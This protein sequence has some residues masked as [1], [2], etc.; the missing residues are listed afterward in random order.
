MAAQNGKKLQTLQA[1]IFL[2]GNKR[3][4]IR[5]PRSCRTTC[6]ACR[7]RLTTQGVASQCEGQGIVWHKLSAKSLK[8][9]MAHVKCAVEVVK[10]CINAPGITFFHQ[11]KILVTFHE[12]V[13][14]LEWKSCCF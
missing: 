13:G 9:P 10:T 11:N 8:S 2:A 14:Q 4:T 12:D 7:G 6:C 3:A 5:H 1:V